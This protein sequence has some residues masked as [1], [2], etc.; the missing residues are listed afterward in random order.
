[1][2]FVR[3]LRIGMAT[4]V[5]LTSTSSTFLVGCVSKAKDDGGGLDGIV[6]DPVPP[7][8]PYNGDQVHV[9]P[10]LLFENDK[11]ALKP[12][13]MAELDQV[14]AYLNEC[15][16]DT[17]TI[18]GHTDTVG[19]ETYNLALGLRRAEAAKAYLVQKGIAADRIQTVSRGEAAPAVPNDTPQNQQ[20]NR[21]VTFS[22]NGAD[23]AK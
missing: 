6:C 19:S 22:V 7:P 20:L 2:K 15:P 23:P 10:N 4:A 3:L 5:T 12:E 11:T 9:M 13:A 16:K 21:R 1:M 18:E 14:C 17:L 8:P